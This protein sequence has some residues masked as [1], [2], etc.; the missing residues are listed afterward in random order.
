MTSSSGVG[1]FPIHFCHLIWPFTLFCV[2]SNF[3]AENLICNSH[4]RIEET[5]MSIVRS[6]IVG[7]IGFP[8]TCFTILSVSRLYRL[9][10][11]MNSELR[12]D[13]EGRR[14]FQIQLIHLDDLAGIEKY[15]ENGQAR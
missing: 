2:L 9:G 4:L 6:K 5:D 15:C 7:K 10:S 14:L 11:L 13:L 12:T 1:S 3:S 8:A